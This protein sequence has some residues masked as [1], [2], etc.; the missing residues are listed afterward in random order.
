V[1]VGPMPSYDQAQGTKKRVER[2]YATA[3]IFP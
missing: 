2:K 3:M 1:R